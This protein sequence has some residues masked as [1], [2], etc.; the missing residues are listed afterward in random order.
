MTILV[1]E[2]DVTSRLIVVRTLRNERYTVVEAR[3]GEEAIERFRAGNID[4]VVTDWMMPKSDGIELITQ[5]RSMAEQPVFIVMLTAIATAEAERKALESGADE[6]LTKP[7]QPKGLVEILARGLAVTGSGRA[8]SHLLGNSKAAKIRSYYGVGIAS[9]TGGPQTLLKVFDKIPAT[10][11]AAIFMV[12]HGPAWMLES[13][14][15]RLQDVCRMPVVMA[16]DGMKFAPGTVYLSRG[17]FHTVVDPSA[18]V[19]RMIDDPPENFCKPAADPLFRSIAAA[20]GPAAISIVL[21]GMGRDGTIGSGYIAAAGGRVIAQDPKTAILP[22]MPQ[23]VVDLRIATHIVPLDRIG[24]EF[25]SMINAP[26]M[27]NPPAKVYSS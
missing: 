4:A 21:S 8:A 11:R 3:N 26:V 14:R 19:L 15:A 18:G 23:S 16:D 24:T 2:D 7:V 1:A 22:S 13:F 25:T 10:D 27:M 6:F 17:D 9:S 20:F 5:I 12:Q